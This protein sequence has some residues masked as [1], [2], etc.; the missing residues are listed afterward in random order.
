MVVYSRLPAG[1]VQRAR[2]CINENHSYIC[3]CMTNTWHT[4]S[5]ERQTVLVHFQLYGRYSSAIMPV[6]GH[7]AKSN[8]ENIC[9]WNMD[10]PIMKH[11]RAKNKVKLTT[12]SG[13]DCHRWTLAIIDTC[14][15]DLAGWNQ[16][17]VINHREL[18]AACW[19]PY[20]NTC[21]TTTTY[22]HMKPDLPN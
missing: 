14:V 17:W 10:M 13:N 5:L 8:I 18:I 11:K 6:H 19:W 15:K 20:W 4:N 16:K 7:D 22:A 9:T 2:L 12:K 1:R 3:I 21:E